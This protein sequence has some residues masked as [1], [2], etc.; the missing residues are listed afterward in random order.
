MVDRIDRGT[1][2]FERE[3]S[4]QLRARSAP[5]GF[6]D[7]LMARLPAARKPRSRWQSLWNPAWS[8]AFIAALV[9]V[10]VLGGLEH[11]RQQRIAGER[12]RDQVILALHIAGSTLNQ[13]QQKV[14]QPDGSASDH[15]GKSSHT[16]DLTP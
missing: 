12:A 10:T 13:V 2:D 7:R 15:A 6:A 8:W 3:L 5:T 14:N 1:D 9:A 16:I 11:N 4:N